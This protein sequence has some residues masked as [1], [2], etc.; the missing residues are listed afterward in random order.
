[1]PGS[2][3]GCYQR[4]RVQLRLAMSFV[5]GHMGYNMRLMGV[6]LDSQTVLGKGCTRGHYALFSYL[7]KADLKATQDEEFLMLVRLAE[8]PV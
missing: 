3:S 5:R 8:D 6:C 4:P 1:M 2:A 7:N